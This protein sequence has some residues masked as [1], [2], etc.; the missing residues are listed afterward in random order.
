[1]K[2]S[3]FLSHFQTTVFHGISHDDL[4]VALEYN[5]DSRRYSGGYK[6]TMPSF[7]SSAPYC[8]DTVIVLQKLQEQSQPTDA[9][10]Y[11]TYVVELA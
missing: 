5:C 9:N 3:Q 10:Y 4:N 7:K 1:M 11:P 8:D 2:Q 6:S